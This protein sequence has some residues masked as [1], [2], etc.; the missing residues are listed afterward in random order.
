MVSIASWLVPSS[1]S[2]AASLTL[3]ATLRAISS[4]VALLLTNKAETLFHD[5]FF[6]FVSITTA[7]ATSEVASWS[8]VVSE[9][10]SGFKSAASGRSGIVES[11]RWAIVSETTTIAIAAWTVTSWRHVS[12]FSWW[13]VSGA[14][15]SIAIP[16]SFLW[17]KAVGSFG[18]W[19]WTIVDLVSQV[20]TVA[21]V[22]ASVTI[23]LSR[24][25]TESW[26][27]VF[28]AFSL[29]SGS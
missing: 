9:A 6:L 29:S 18:S 7:K 12:W 26:V 28:S 21:E 1:V 11:S 17:V 8:A 13:E 27:R 16:H 3:L 22:S 23:E 2:E 14:T 5:S 4:H 20:S 25:A 10:T 15:K 24:L 19:H